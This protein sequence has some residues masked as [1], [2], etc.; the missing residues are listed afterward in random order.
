MFFKPKPKTSP[1]IIPTNSEN[2]TL[3]KMKYKLDEAD[4]KLE[5]IV[6][7]THSAIHEEVKTLAAIKDQRLAVRNQI[8]LPFS[9]YKYDKNTAT[10]AEQLIYNRAYDDLEC[11]AAF[12]KDVDINHR[13]ASLR[14]YT[15]AVNESY[16]MEG[17]NTKTS[18]LTHMTPQQLQKLQFRSMAIAN[19]EL[20][21]QFKD[22]KSSESETRETLKLLNRIKD[23]ALNKLK[24]YYTD[25]AGYNARH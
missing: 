1:S 15:D 17:I 10:T 7:E 13:L 24:I 22:I 9:E 16:T 19:P 23:V 21:Q 14:G 12:S 11:N 25:H 6:E 2:K 20:E 3:K 8:M 18:L 4:K 5:K